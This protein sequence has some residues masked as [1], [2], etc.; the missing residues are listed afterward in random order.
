MCQV[1]IAWIQTV[2]LLSAPAFV[3][4]YL[5]YWEDEGSVTAVPVTCVE[6]GEVGARK[7]VKQGKDSYEGKLIYS[8]K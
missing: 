8:G 6:N 3:G 2:N 1:S 5:V 7:A 4:Y